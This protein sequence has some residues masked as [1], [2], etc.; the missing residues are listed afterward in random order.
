MYANSNGLG[1]YEL[2]KRPGYIPGALGWR[3]RGVCFDW[4]A[5]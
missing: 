4:F 5:G 2:L 3:E 1:T